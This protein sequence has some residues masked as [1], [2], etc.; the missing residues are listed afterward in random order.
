VATPDPLTHIFENVWQMQGSE[1][2]NSEVW[3]GKGLSAF[4]R[5]ETAEGPRAETE[6]LDENAMHRTKDGAHRII[7]V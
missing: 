2:K 1:G 4:W 7:S 6:D 3:Q 5:R